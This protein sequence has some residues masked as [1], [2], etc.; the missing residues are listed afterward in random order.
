MKKHLYERNIIE[1]KHE[2]T[3]LLL[4]IMTKNIYDGI[5]SIFIHAVSTEQLLIKNNASNP[6]LF[7]IFQLYL[8]DVNVINTNEIA[9]EVNRIKTVSNSSEWF[10]D[11]VKAVVKS[12]IVLLTYNVSE[13]TCALI[14]SKYHEQINIVDFVH[15]CY[16]EVCDIF[17]ENYEFVWHEYNKNIHSCESK[18]FKNELIEMIKNGINMAIRKTLQIKL[19]VSEYLANDYINI[20]DEKNVDKQKT[21][22]LDDK[23]EETKVVTEIKN[24]VVDA[25]TLDTEKSIEP[26][27]ETKFDDDI[28]IRNVFEE[29]DKIDH[30][31]P[32]THSDK[33]EMP[34]IKHEEQIKKQSTMK[35]SKHELSNKYDDIASINDNL[36]K[37]Q[38]LC[39]SVTSS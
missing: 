15:K 10:D 24:V 35:K 26:I 27:V 38:E 17:S 19:I 16:V 22:I 13:K 30:K 3:Q 20:T 39:E 34:I 32:T 5:K 37:L 25:K 11:L 1:I 23:K 21:Q 8:K 33:H 7:K 9:K 12:N 28:D 6:G 36:S 14:D 2:Y 4:N 29:S 18:K 31:T